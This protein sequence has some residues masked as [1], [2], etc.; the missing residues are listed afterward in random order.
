M[1]DQHSAFNDTIEMLFRSF[2]E[3]VIPKGSIQRWLR[4]FDDEDKL[5]AITLLRHV[6]YHSQPRVMRETRLLHQ[7]VLKRLATSG[8][9]WRT[10]QDID[11]SR[12]FTCKSGDVVSYIYRK[13]NL[14]PTVDFKTFDELTEETMDHS[15][16]FKT[17]ALVILDDYIGTG[18]QFIFQFIGRSDED[19]RVVNSYGKTYLACYVIHEKALQNFQRLAE[20]RI[21]EV[22]RIEKEQFPDVDFSLE[23]EERLHIT[24]TSL[25][26]QNIE[27]VYLEAEEPLL[28]PH[29]RTL[30]D[31]E[32]GRIERLLDKY[33]HEGYAGT[34][35]LLGHHAFF[36]GAP[37]SL[38]EILWPLFNRIEDL[39]IYSGEKPVGFEGDVIRYSIDD[40][41]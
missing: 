1:A 8:F 39:S 9:D 10:L 20:G 25:D 11:F 29:N 41:S 35:Y 30:D 27:L 32:K 14:I 7:K 21:D 22:I 26:W 40:E 2:N 18:S 37:N 24:L 15:D 4:R 33:K 19:I 12:E 6:E 28:S 17:R 31:E 38:P 36:F 3:P 13:S 5:A 23:E 16:R 34:S